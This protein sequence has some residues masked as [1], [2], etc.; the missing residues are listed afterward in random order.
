MSEFVEVIGLQKAQALFDAN[1]LGRGFAIGLYRA[2]QEVAAEMQREAKPH[3]WHGRLEQQIHANPPT[4]TG[5]NTEVRVGITTGLA[6]E[7][8]PL[9]FGWKSEGG[10]QPP[11]GP[12]SPLADWVATHIAGASSNVTRN[13]AGRIR[14][15]G[16][17]ASITAEPGVQRIA[18]LIAR[19][20]ARTG[21]R[22]GSDDWFHK[23]ITAAR[24]R[25]AGIVARFTREAK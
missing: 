3:H 8:R 7:G 21:Y 4:G 24:P 17:I 6:P 16:S 23:G 9:A 20:I 22:F 10:K 14:R 25:L 13:A 18:F 15:K 5:L 19:K 1:R 2:G 12:G 11:S